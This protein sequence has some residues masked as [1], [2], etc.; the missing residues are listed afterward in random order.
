MARGSFADK[1]VPREAAPTR[2]TPVLQWTIY[3]V[4]PGMIIE[5]AVVGF[6]AAN[7]YLVGC[8]ET[9]EGVVIDPGT[10]DTSDTADVAGE[11]RR[12]GLGIK[13][14]LNTHG[15]PDHMS[16]NDLLKVAVGGEVLVHQLDALKLTDPVRNAS[17]LFGMDM[18]V[19]PA[20]GL[21]KDGDGIS[22]GRQT[23]K[24]AHT[25]G[26]SIGGV[27][28]IGDGF[29]FTGD[30]LF[31]G[32]IG[33]SDL[34]DSSDADTVAYDVLLDSIRDKLLTLPDDT[35]VLTGHGPATTIGNERAGNPFLR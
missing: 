26:H 9:M 22:F 24:V 25:P 6:A 34:P 3:D 27:V 8:R 17:R 12:L 21:L 13:Y 23:L 20:D 28:F 4:H 19:S 31:A 18:H 16:G 1:T 11:I 7:C 30:T 2:R 10:M 29:V 15:H 35:V 5:S 32:S 14:I 33:R